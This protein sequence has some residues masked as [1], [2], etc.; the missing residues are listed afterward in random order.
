[1]NVALIVILVVVILAVVGLLRTIRIV[2]HATA[3]IVERF[4]RYHRTL[5]AGPSIVIPFIDRMRPLVD[6]REQIVSFPPQPVPTRDNL[7]VSV[8]TVISFEVTDPKAATYGVANFVTAMEQQSITTLRNVIV[9]MDLERTLSSRDQINEELHRKLNEVGSGW[10]IRIKRVELK[11]IDP[12]PSMQDAMEKQMR[13]DRERRAALAAAEGEKQSSILS[14]EGEKQAAV[15]RARG[16]SEAVVLKAK[17]DAEAQA[18]RA[19]GQAEAIS[20]VFR[21]IHDGNPS[22]ELLAYQYL[23]T[24]PQIAEGSANKVWIVPSEMGRALE[25][26]GGFFGGARSM[27]RESPDGQNG[28]STSEED[29]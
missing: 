5:T 25:G 15:L 27:R 20:T 19:Q 12:P 22:T 21:A 29:R 1:M 2:P 13:A 14:A 23:Q 11:A 18:V 7:A 10:G 26:I 16:E 24:L 3:G 9:G 8:D 6:L 4:G 17:A 28:Q